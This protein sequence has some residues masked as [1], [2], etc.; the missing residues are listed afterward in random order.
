MI[1]ASKPHLRCCALALLFSLV[2]VEDVFAKTTR[3]TSSQPS[4]EENSDTT[5]AASELASQVSEIAHSAAISRAK[6]E[7]RISTA[8]RVAVVA[9]TAYKHDAKEVLNTV[10]ELTE[11][12]AAA[13]PQF[14][15]V[16]TNAV[17]FAPALSRID[18]APSQIRTAAFSAAKAPKAS[19]KKN[20]AASKPRASAQ[21][22]VSQS[23][24]YAQKKHPE[25]SVSHDEVEPASS[26]P[27]F[28]TDSAMSDETRSTPKVSLSNNSNFSVTADLSVR[29]DDNVYLRSTNKVGD[30]IIAVTPG[31]EY[32]FGQNSLAHGSISYKNAITRYA[33]KSSP[34]VAL[35]DAAADFGYDSGS[36]TILGNAVFQ[37]LN[38]NNNTVAAVGQNTIFRR[39]VLGL[40]TSV[41]SHLTAKTSLMT[42]VNYNKS[43]YKTGGLIG[44]MDTSV[45]LKFYFETTPKVSLFTGVSYRHV[46]PQNGGPRGK[47][48]DYSIGARGNF[49][50]KLNGALSVNYRTRTVGIKPKENLWG[51]N[52][53]LSYEVTPKTSSSLIFSRDFSVGALGESLKNSS[54]AFRLTSDLTPQWQLG[55]GLVF[56]QTEF[57][58]YLFRLNNVPTLG[59]RTDNSWDGD[60]QASYL[61]SSWLTLSANYTLRHNS[62]TLP[63]AEYNNSILSLIM[64]W[65]Y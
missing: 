44:S 46:T 61:F 64:G 23:Q 40:N 11:A 30:T 34:N 35:S 2:T 55:A 60:V 49:T 47:D 65:R 36:L 37:Q 39:D 57:G 1:A 6:K 17:A 62:S 13:A 10:L 42:G 16:I 28:V 31:V 29:R 20:V 7:K 51:L 9:A 8:V 18:S 63:G 50:A 43:E 14:A 45:P 33:D 19:R 41:E 58:A 54:Y 22:P 59:N 25:Q 32:H 56:R 24:T 3:P 12:A 48:M 5:D 21:Q 15:E 26:S 4:M 52:G 53:N 27:D 38:Q